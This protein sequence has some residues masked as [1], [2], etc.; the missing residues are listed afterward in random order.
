MDLPFGTLSEQRG[1]GETNAA[2]FEGVSKFFYLVA[3]VSSVT[4]LHR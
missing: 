1:R 4:H 2:G 3:R